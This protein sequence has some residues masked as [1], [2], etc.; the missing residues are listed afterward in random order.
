MKTDPSLI[1]KFMNDLETI[2][3]KESDLQTSPSSEQDSTG[4]NSL[5]TLRQIIL[6]LWTISP[7]DLFVLQISP[8]K[9]QI[10]EIRKHKQWLQRRR[11]G[12]YR[13]QNHQE[14][15]TNEE[16]EDENSL[17]SP[18]DT[19]NEESD[20]YL[21]DLYAQA[22]QEQEDRYEEEQREEEE[23]RRQQEQDSAYYAYVALSHSDD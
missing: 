22:R 14:R 2:A 7:D 19:H 13:P 3:Q 6:T 16:W 11:T 9:K 4:N 1:E 23:F 10:Q 18:L 20:T 8:R 17:S 15:D 21:E 5:P 12:V